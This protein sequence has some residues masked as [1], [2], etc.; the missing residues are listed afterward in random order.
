MLLS[1]DT[2][3]RSPSSI[4]FDDE[5]QM[6]VANTLDNS[7]TVY[8]ATW[9]ADNTTP[10]RTLVGPGTGLDSPVSIA[11]DVDGQMHVLNANSITVYPANWASGD[12]EPLRTLSGSSTGLVNPTGLALDS[13]GRIYVTNSGSL[14]DGSM[15]SVTVYASDWTAANVKPVATLAGSGTGLLR[16]RA[17]AFDLAG[18]MYVVNSYGVS[19]YEPSWE[20]G[21]TAPSRVLAGPGTGMDDPRAVAFDDAGYMYIANAGRGVVS[22]AHITIFKPT[23]SNGNTRPSALII[24]ANLL[25]TDP[26]AL[27]FDDNGLLYVANQFRDSVLAYQTQ[28]LSLDPPKRR[29]LE[30]AHGQGIGILIGRTAH[31]HHHD[32]PRGLHR[33]GDLAHHHHHQGYGYLLARDHAGGRRATRSGSRHQRELP[34]DDST[35]GH[36]RVW[37]VADLRQQAVGPSE[38][39]DHERPARGVDDTDP[40]RVH[41]PEGLRSARAAQGHRDVHDVGVPARQLPLVVRGSCEPQLRGHALGPRWSDWGTSTPVGLETGLLVRCAPSLATDEGGLP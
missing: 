38:G 40:G 10:L 7:V 30:H 20:S 3:L 8:P 13:T 26:R 31:V 17:L 24:G 4:A 28:T 36:H 39:L 21:N 37:P 23:W 29:A 19:V 32:Q 14:S 5:G 6:Y 12:T 15:A 34:G 18:Y 11:F 33:I 1:R 35:S 27:A 25:L 9:L 41:S 2:G 22:R 16:P